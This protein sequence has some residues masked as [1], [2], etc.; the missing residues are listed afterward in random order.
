MPIRLFLG[1][2]ID[3]GIKRL[4]YFPL[5]FI[6]RLAI[7]LSLIFLRPCPILQ[8]LISLFSAIAVMSIQIVVYQLLFH[9]YTDQFAHITS[10]I[11]DG[12]VMLIFMVLGLFLW[13][14]D[15]ESKDL[16]AVLLMVIVFATVASMTILSIYK[17]GLTV[18]RLIKECNRELSRSKRPI[19]RSIST[20][21]PKKPSLV[22]IHP[23]PP[24][25]LIEEPDSGLR[26]PVPTPVSHTS[27]LTKR[28]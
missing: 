8:I 14:I 16:Y 6:E 26:D 17:M 1:F 9:P 23:L 24:A 5:F 15:S 27:S 4:L 19:I 13:P 28:S 3:K 10:L 11:S 25:L 20:F 2:N 21:G 18:R 22:K 12:S 7:S